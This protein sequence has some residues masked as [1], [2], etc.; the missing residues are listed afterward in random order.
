VVFRYFTIDGSLGITQKL[1]NAIVVKEIEMKQKKLNLVG[2]LIMD[3]ILVREAVHFNGKHLQGCINYGHKT[4]DS[5][6]IPKAIEVLVF[7]IVALN[8]HWKIPVAYF[9]INVLTAEE[10]A[11]LLETCLIN[12][13]ETGAIVKTITFDG[14]TSNTSNY[15]H[16]YMDL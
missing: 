4:N 1:L 2:G 14:A 10:K 16:F 15:A 11:N 12:V 8:S 13:Q 5:D 7:L 3:E 9:L 6:A